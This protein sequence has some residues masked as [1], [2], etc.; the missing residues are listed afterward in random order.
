MAATSNIKIVNQFAD[1]STRTLEF[2]PFDPTSAAFTN[3]KTNIKNFDPSDI[4]NIYLSD[5]GSSYTGI[6]A[7]TLTVLEETPFNLNDVE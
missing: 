6:T 4:A 7:A 2:G 5:G 3:A 1:D